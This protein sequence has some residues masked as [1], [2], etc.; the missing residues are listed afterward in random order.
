M[1]ISEC[2]NYDPSSSFIYLALHERLVRKLYD[3]TTLFGPI[4]N[5][6][7]IYRKKKKKRR[8][9]LGE[10]GGVTA[11]Q[12]W[13]KTIQNHTHHHQI[14]RANLAHAKETTKKTTISFLSLAVFL[15]HLSSL[16]IKSFSLYLSKPYYTCI[17]SVN[18]L[19]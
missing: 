14:E 13:P 6:R 5:F 4:F 15:C 12:F 17:Y 19:N 3:S 8:R 2:L 10:W 1:F 7:S 18:F 9:I 16:S 11:T